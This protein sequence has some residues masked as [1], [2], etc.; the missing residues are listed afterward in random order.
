MWIGKNGVTDGVITEISRQLKR[1][2]LVKI[3]FLRNFI[4]D[5]DKKEISRKLSEKTSSEIIDLVGNV[6]V[7]HKAYSEN[8]LKKKDLSA[9]HD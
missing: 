5:K 8:N 7:L 1:K 3:K 4:E 9:K 6:L 2:K